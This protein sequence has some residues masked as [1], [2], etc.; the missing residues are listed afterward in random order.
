MDSLEGHKSSKYSTVCDNEMLTNG[1][2][3]LQGTIRLSMVQYKVCTIE[4][5]A[6]F[7]V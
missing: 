5:A 4:A 3:L 2:L 7:Y 1:S 6:L